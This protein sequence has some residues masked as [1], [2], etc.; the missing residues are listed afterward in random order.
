MTKQELKAALE[1]LAAKHTSTVSKNGREFV[2]VPSVSEVDAKQG[3][4]GFSVSVPCNYYVHKPE[5][6]A[7]VMAIRSELAKMTGADMTRKAKKLDIPG[8]WHMG[9]FSPDCVASRHYSAA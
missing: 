8:L 4:P 3:M 5:A 1:M 6:V 2:V 9:T 7:I